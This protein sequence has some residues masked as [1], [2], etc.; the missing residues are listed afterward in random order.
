MAA[1]RICASCATLPATGCAIPERCQVKNCSVCG[2]TVR[3]DPEATIPA[4]G[5]EVIVCD[6]CVEERFTEALQKLADIS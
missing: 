2:I 4:L 6:G 5:T 3:Y 1:L